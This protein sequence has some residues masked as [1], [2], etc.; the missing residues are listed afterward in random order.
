MLPLIA[1]ALC[2][3]A[4]ACG[5]GGCYDNQNAIPLAQF[6]EIG[7]SKS[8]SISGVG[9]SGVG[10]PNDSVLVQPSQSISQVYLPM[11]SSASSTAW[12]FHY[13]GE[14]AS[15]ETDNDTITFNYSSLPFFASEEC[16]A[17]YYYK[18][19]SF[20]YTTHLIDSVAVT[21]SLITNVDIPRINIYF[22]AASDEGGEGGDDNSDNEGGD[23][24]N[25]NENA[26]GEESGN[27]NAG[28]GGQQ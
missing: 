1:A 25:G 10:A 28:E 20:S 3:A 17:M 26:G 5:S 9:I 27:E 15:V 14:A 13:T 6:L 18:I 24:N 8:I 7:T 19:T 2:L 4:G 22:R 23:D 12:C 16:G 11:R 21:D